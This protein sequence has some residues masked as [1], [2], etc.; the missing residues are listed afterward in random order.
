MVWFYQHLI[1]FGVMKRSPVCC[2]V[3]IHTHTNIH[4]TFPV[5]L[6][7]LAAN[8]T[9][10]GGKVSHRESVSS[11]LFTCIVEFLLMFTT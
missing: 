11:F 3:R 6:I 9:T 7:N 4:T 8:V 1:L 5:S 10:V 2:R